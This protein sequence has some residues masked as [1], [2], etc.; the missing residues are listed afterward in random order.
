MTMWLGGIRGQI[1]VGISKSNQGGR[2]NFHGLVALADFLDLGGDDGHS[3]GGVVKF[4]VHAASDKAEFE[5]GASPCGT[6]DG[7]EDGLG[8]IERM[9]GEVGVIIA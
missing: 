2:G 9:S 4:E 8:A 5:H 1:R 6:G 7:N 3:V